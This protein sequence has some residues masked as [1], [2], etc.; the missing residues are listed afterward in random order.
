MKNKDY[1]KR[2]L[3]PDG[4]I[5]AQDIDRT[6]VMMCYIQMSLLGC[7]AVVVIGDIKTI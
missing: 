2:V 7:P 1:K 5:L 3:Y 4:K 6:A